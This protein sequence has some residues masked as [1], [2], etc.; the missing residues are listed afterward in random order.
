M[1]TKNASIEKRYNVGVKCYHRDAQLDFGEHLALQGRRELFCAVG[2]V[3]ETRC[4]DSQIDGDGCLGVWPQSVS[5]IEV[6]VDL[7]L[8][9]S[10]A[11]WINNAASEQWMW[12]HLCSQSRKGLWI[13]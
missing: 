1:L 3:R 6:M 11:D 9:R 7:Q 13:K 2:V 5:Q 12:K 10:S 8:N 4:L